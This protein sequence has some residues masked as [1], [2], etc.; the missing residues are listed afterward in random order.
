MR[1]DDLAGAPLSDSPQPLL[2][3]GQTE[4][5]EFALGVPPLELSADFG[6]GREGNRFYHVTA[7][8]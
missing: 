6:S 7:F 5:I 2:E 4:G 1:Q 8:R 3:I